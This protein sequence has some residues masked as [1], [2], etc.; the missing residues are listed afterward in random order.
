[1]PPF[2]IRTFRVVEHRTDAAQTFSLI[3]T[4]ADGEPLFP[5]K[6]GQ[7]VMAHLLNPDKTVWAKAAYS[8]ATAPSECTDSIEL[9]IKLHGDFT[10]RLSDLEVG[11][12]IGIQGPYGAF[13]LKD[14]EP[15]IVFFAGGVGV[16]PLRSM[17][18]EALLTQKNLELVL[19][20]SDKTRG[21]MAYEAEFRELAAEY[22]NFRFVPFITR[23]TPEEWDGELTRIERMIV[24]KY[25]T[26]W[27]VGRYCMCGPDA[28][29]DAIKAMLDEV[30]VD[31]KVKLQRESFG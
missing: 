13:T 31:T 1:M 12:E 4:P 17:I 7:F 18:R 25:L 28:F 24:E 9:G 11:D 30:G 27:N 29:M 15:R 14:D 8:L 22:P 3:L 10:K 26:D 16:T 21:D 23:E 19:F 5:F 20:Y 6:A 2:P